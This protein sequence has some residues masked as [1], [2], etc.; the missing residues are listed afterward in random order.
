MK[1]ELLQDSTPLKLT[2]I[3]AADKNNWVPVMSAD[4]GLGAESAIKVIMFYFQRCMEFCST[5]TS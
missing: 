1:R 3:D 2:K 4:I 5:L